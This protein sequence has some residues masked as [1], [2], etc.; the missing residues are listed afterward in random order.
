MS[1]LVTQPEVARI[2]DRIWL[3]RWDG[4]VGPWPGIVVAH[5]GATPTL[6]VFG[7]EAPAIIDANVS[8][9][10]V[11]D[12]T[13]HGWILEPADREIPGDLFA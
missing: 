8:H 2:G 1:L 5:P 13:D 3:M 12:G 9:W 7:P 4:A 11:E 6:V 10:L